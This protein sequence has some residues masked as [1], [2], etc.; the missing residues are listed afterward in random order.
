M[1]RVIRNGNARV[2]PRPLVEAKN[3]AARI[4]AQAHTDAARIRDERANELATEARAH[5]RAELAEARLSLEHAHGE[6]LRGASESIVEIALAVAR[7]LVGEELALRPERVREIVDEAIERV[8][9]AKGARVRVHPE[10]AQQLVDLHVHIVE[11]DSIT[12]GGCLVESELGDV[13]ARLE[14]RLEALGRA[15]RNAAT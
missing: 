10:D 1:A 7:R 3:E 8:R 13:D 14:V 2:I 15:L 5:A 12:R 6:M 4:V 9:R 11:D